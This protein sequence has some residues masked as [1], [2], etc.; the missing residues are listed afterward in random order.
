MDIVVFVTV[1][2]P[3]QLQHLTKKRVSGN[4]CKR[5]PKRYRPF[6]DKRGDQC[7]SCSSD[8]FSDPLESTVDD[9]MVSYISEGP[10]MLPIAHTREPS[11]E[12]SS[13]SIPALH[14]ICEDE[15]E[16]MV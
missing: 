1:S 12:S 15:D 10:T 4:P 5:P 9:S 13:V 16:I 14:N 2:P 7:F 11:W 6:L 3:S 8:D